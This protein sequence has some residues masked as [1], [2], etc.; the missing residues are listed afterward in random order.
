MPTARDVMAT[1]VLTIPHT[2]SVGEAIQMVLAGEVECAPVIDG[3]GRLLGFVSEAQLLVVFY[4][5]EVREERITACLSDDVV[6]IEADT[7]LTDVGRKLNRSGAPRLAV[8]ENGRLV[9][10]ISRADLVQHIAAAPLASRL[11]MPVAA[12]TLCSQRGHTNPTHERRTG[13]EWLSISKSAR[14]ANSARR[15]SKLD[16]DTR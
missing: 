6:S 15:S 1:D 5:D 10:T 13:N 8:L 12:A 16:S 2:A 14:R 9:G 7:P 11:S 3:R 4:D